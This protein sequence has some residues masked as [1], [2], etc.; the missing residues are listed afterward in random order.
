MAELEIYCNPFKIS[1]LESAI[2]AGPALSI[3]IT[4]FLLN[5]LGPIFTLK[6]C[7][8]V[9]ICFML[10]LFQMKNIYIVTLSF[11][12]IFICTYTMY[13]CKSIY[14]VEMCETKKR[15]LYFGILNVMSGVSGIFVV[16]I[17]H[18]YNKLHICF[19]C[20]IIAILIVICILHF[21]VV[22]SVR[23]SFLNKKYNNVIKDLKKI[24]I[25]NGNTDKLEIWIKKI[26]EGELMPLDLGEISHD[27]IINK[28]V[29]LNLVKFE[30]ENEAKVK[31]VSSIVNHKII[32]CKELKKINFLS[33]LKF[34][35]Q[36]NTLLS[37]TLIIFIFKF[38]NVF[39]LLELGHSKTLNNM[40]LFFIIDC[41]TNITSAILVEK[42]WMGR[43]KF[44]FYIMILNILVR[45]PLRKELSRESKIILDI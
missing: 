35:S 6:V 3:F 15:S 8:F 42:P 32:Y 9:Y 33:I 20:N 10:M 12:G 4:P 16:I 28:E 45:N 7:G 27:K 5:N 26:K 14:I 31:F 41:I 36:I 30:D 23:F 39:L 25:F 2:F 21:R 13:S 29:E 1:I 11:Y 40:I 34:K 17:I 44:T 37:F 19:I 43:R 24:A 18:Y 22:E 38:S